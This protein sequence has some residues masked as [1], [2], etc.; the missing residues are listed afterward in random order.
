M[1][2]ATLRQKISELSSSLSEK[3]KAFNQLKTSLL[4]LFNLAM[5]DAQALKTTQSELISQLQTAI[6]D[7]QGKE[8]D[9][10]AEFNELQ[11]AESQ[12]NSLMDQLSSF[13]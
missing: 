6:S 1:S 5:Q 8:S 11:Q 13:Q 7:M 3:N 10:Q 4:E 12:Y 2:L 9:L